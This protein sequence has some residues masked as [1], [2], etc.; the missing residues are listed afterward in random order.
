[1]SVIYFERYNAHC[2]IWQFVNEDVNQDMMQRWFLMV[3]LEVVADDRELTNHTNDDDGN[4]IDH[5]KLDN[6]RK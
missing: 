3:D 4:D 1:M 5:R 6:A 2:I